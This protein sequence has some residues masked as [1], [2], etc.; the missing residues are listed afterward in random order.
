[1]GK[2]EKDELY[3]I[4]KAKDLCD[5]IFTI[6]DKSP[7]KFRFTF[8]SKLQNIGL[9]II[10]NLYYAN[11]V[12]VRN[13]DDIKR[14]D[15]RKEYQQEAYVQL[16]LLDYMAMMAREHM[17]I[18]PKQY[19]QISMQAAE[20]IMLLVKWSRSDQDRYNAAVKHDKQ[21]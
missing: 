19:N 14:I 8:T 4:I 5:Y 9:N 17:A 10:Q 7:K 16:K 1:M 18:L 12:Y 11:M 3:V 21:G 15:K 20:V 13:S 2:K 6:T